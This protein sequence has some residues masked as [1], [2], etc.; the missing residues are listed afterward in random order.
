MTL[1]INKVLDVS[2]AHIPEATNTAL[3]YGMSELN[4]ILP[5]TNWSD[6]GWI[7]WTGGAPDSLDAFGEIAEQHPELANLIR[8]CQD[9]GILYLQLDCDGEQIDGFPT[10]EW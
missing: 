7:I 6:Y 9:N 8:L 2:T 10:F 1:L 4:G 5:M 3:L